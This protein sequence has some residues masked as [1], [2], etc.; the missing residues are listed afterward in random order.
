M[1]PARMRDELKPAIERHYELISEALVR[2]VNVKL[3]KLR[4]TN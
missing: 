2:K 1:M 3:Q 4:T